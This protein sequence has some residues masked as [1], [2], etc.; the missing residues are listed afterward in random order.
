MRM[1]VSDAAAGELGRPPGVDGGGRG[2]C[3]GARSIVRVLGEEVEGFLHEAPRERA[4]VAGEEEGDAAG[5]LRAGAEG[6]GA[7]VLRQGRA[8][9]EGAPE[10]VRQTLGGD[11][12]D[13]GEEAG[14]EHGRAREV[15]D[16]RAV[17]ADVL[18]PVPR[19]AQELARGRRVRVGDRARHQ[20][21]GVAAGV[22]LVGD[23]PRAREVQGRHVVAHGS[24]VAPGA[25]GAAGD[26]AEDL[27]RE[28]R[29][30][31]GELVGHVSQV[32]ILVPVRG[33]LVHQAARGL[34]VVQGQL[35][36]EGR[37]GEAGPGLV[38]EGVGEGD[39]TLEQLPRPV[40]LP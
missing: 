20:A 23:L 27:L 13:H 38:R 1:A 5:L 26:R 34:E 40:V 15:G 16:A 11:P 9:G 8:E 33:E 39:R 30:P 25:E 28:G 12:L 17:L 24:H 35:L 37:A 6:V 21:V 14:A 22:A 7:A 3:G 10:G 32:P 36:G 19:L 29:V 31:A 4:V 2:E 18:E